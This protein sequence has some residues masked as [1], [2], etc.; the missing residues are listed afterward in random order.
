MRHKS[1]LLHK[2]EKS[3]HTETV[4]Q[5][6]TGYIKNGESLLPKT[7]SALF[8]INKKWKSSCTMASTVHLNSFQLPLGKFPTAAVLCLGKFPQFNLDRKLN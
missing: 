6:E 2:I 3:S 4:L 5:I 7:P 1:N 8:F